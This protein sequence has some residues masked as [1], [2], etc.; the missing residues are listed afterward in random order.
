MRSL[1]EWDKLS[2]FARIKNHFPKHQ[3]NCLYWWCKKWVFCVWNLQQMSICSDLREKT[4]RSAI[5]GITAWIESL[6]YSVLKQRLS[7]RLVFFS[8]HACATCTGTAASKSIK[9]HSIKVFI[10]KCTCEMRF[11]LTPIWFTADYFLS[12]ATRKPSSIFFLIWNA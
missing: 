3:L 11:F 10:H 5:N 2:R 7:L 8:F 9:W 6:S 4:S 12:H 1:S